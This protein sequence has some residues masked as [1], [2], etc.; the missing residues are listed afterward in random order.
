[1]E[2]GIIEVE[3]IKE[4]EEKAEAETKEKKETKKEAGEKT[5]AETGFGPKAGVVIKTASEDPDADGERNRGSQNGENRDCGERPKPKQKQTAEEP[6]FQQVR[7]GGRTYLRCVCEAFCSDEEAMLADNR[8]EGL[9]AVTKRCVNGQMQLLYDITGR[10]SLSGCYEKKT[11]SYDELCG[12]LL[13]VHSCL[14]RM[15]EYLLS[16]SGLVFCPAYLY[17]NMAGRQL[18]FVYLPAMGGGFAEH[19]RELAHF[20]MEHVE[21][22]DERAAM[23]AGQFYQYTA[24]EN[25][26][27]TVFLEENRGYFEKADTKNEEDGQESERSDCEWQMREE[28]GN[29]KMA[30]GQQ[31]GQDRGKSP[32][33]IGLIAAA[34]V[35]AAAWSLSWHTRTL[36][37]AGIFA[38]IA[39]GRSVW[40]TGWARRTL[41]KKEREIFFID[42]HSSGGSAPSSTD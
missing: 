33:L 28:D 42:V 34:A 19:I 26:S 13:S 10:Q 20:L 18:Y 35:F 39:A 21:Y 7:E 9:L 14:N 22:E 12:M 41:E 6:R 2:S 32:V 3:W 1:M 29:Q 38:G 4:A 15:E 11:I 27:L 16:E 24:A 8:P 36:L 25:F 5:G 31:D 37:P 17:T 30:G 23:L 40:Y